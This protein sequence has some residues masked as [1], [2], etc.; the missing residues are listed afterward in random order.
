MTSLATTRE[1]ASE[2]TFI[3]YSIDNFQN[4]DNKPAN[5]NTAFFT[6]G[7]F[8]PGHVGHENMITSLLKIAQK[9]NATTRTEITPE[10]TNIF[11]FVSPSGG[12]TEKN[13]KKTP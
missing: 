12:P 9:H 10:K 7:R 13:H 4:C 2:Q 6:Y 8:Q 1:S 5:T 3:G 11:V